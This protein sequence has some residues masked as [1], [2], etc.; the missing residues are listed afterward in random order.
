MSLPVTI[1]FTEDEAFA[2][3]EALEHLSSDME[4][5]LPDA[6]FMTDDEKELEDIWR[7]MY[8]IAQTAIAKIEGTV[9]ENHIMGKPGVCPRCGN[10]DLE[11]TGSDAR[12]DHEVESNYSCHHCG[13]Q[14]DEAWMYSHK[15]VTR[16]PRDFTPAEVEKWA[17]KTCEC[18]EPECET[19]DGGR[20]VVCIS[21][22]RDAS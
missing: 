6:Q 2:L 4:D 10:H 16:D 20:T 22:G 19:R 12:C 17:P 15:Q 14:F 8:D 7:S 11:Q 13:C 3:A 18:D 9:T 5:R 21:C 1:H